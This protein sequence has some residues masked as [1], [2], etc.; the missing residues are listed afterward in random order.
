MSRLQY[1]PG[2]RYCLIAVVKEILKSSKKTKQFEKNNYDVSSFPSY[3]IKKNSSR[4]AK[5]G[6]SERQRNVPQGERNADKKFV[7]KSTETADSSILE[8]WNN[9]YEV[10]KVCCR[11]LDGSEDQKIVLFDRIALENHSYVATKAERIQNSTRWILTLNKGA[12]QPLHQR[13]DFAQAKREGTRLHDEHMARTQ[14]DFR[15]VPRSQQVRQRKGQAFAGI[16]ECDYAVDPLT[17]WRFRRKLL[18]S[19]CIS[20]ESYLPT[21][22]CCWC[23]EVV[24]NEDPKSAVLVGLPHNYLKSLPHWW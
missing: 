9:D 22:K 12:Q 20:L 18:T 5:H 4:G 17:S 23:R 19:T 11:K 7:R 21:S 1:L 3:D 6:P 8:R 16:E 13:R 24:K 14:Q 2:N 10:Q 15:T